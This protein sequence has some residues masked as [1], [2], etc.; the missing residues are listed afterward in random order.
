M[1]IN[2][3]EILAD[4]QACTGIEDVGEAFM[5][6]E[7]ANW[8]LSD[9]VY[10]VLPQGSQELPSMPLLDDSVQVIGETSSSSG[11]QATR[12]PSSPPSLAQLLQPTPLTSMSRDFLPRRTRILNFSIVLN[13]KTTVIGIPE[14]QSVGMIK[15][16]V[17]S[18]LD[19]PVCKLELS[20]WKLDRQPRDTTILETLNLPKENTLYLSVNTDDRDAATEES[21][22]RMTQIYRLSIHDGTHNQT[23]AINFPGT[24]TILEVKR[25]VSDLTNIPVRNQ[26]WSGWPSQLTDDVILGASG[27]NLVHDLVVKELIKEVN[28]PPEVVPIPGGSNSEPVS[29]DG[30]TA[31]EYE[32]AS[33]VVMEDMFLRELTPSRPQP[34]MP[35]GIEDEAMA[36]ILFAEGFA[37]RYGPCHPMF[38][39]GSLDDAM[40]E[41]CHQPARDRKLLAVYLHHDGSV[42]SN[43]FCTQVLCSE[44]IASFLTANFIIWGWDLTATSNRQRLLNTIA[45]HFDSLASR[46]LRNFEVDKL[47]LLLIVTRS[48][49][50]NEVLAMIPGSL[51]VDEMMTQLLH[52][53]EMFSEQQRVEMAEEEE[54]SARETVKREQDEAYQLSLEADRAKEELKRQGEAVKQRQEEEQRVKQEQEKRLIEFTQQQK[55]MQRQEVLKRLPAEPSADQPAGSIT[56]IRFRLPEGKTSTRRFLADEPLQVLL[57]YLLVEGFPQSEFKV[58]SSW[59]RKDLTAVDL[60]ETLRQLKLVPQETLIIEER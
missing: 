25:D 20:G 52:A 54:R 22:S 47:P 31:D 28:Q 53:V 60:T 30:S 2:R 46:T 6:L 26:L 36:A 43:V 1:S 19:I 59:P 41:A 13:D 10:R 33:D 14:S 5:H 44:S 16:L 17:S 56:C 51:N 48:R 38:F 21:V 11:F 15:T 39:P 32:D 12:P 9:A 45:R 27:I 55:E 37:Q 58:L 23:H 24:K 29:D 40:K 18:E 57:D 7:D 3:E 50:T 42:S 4:F 8:D 49:A 34:L 35:E